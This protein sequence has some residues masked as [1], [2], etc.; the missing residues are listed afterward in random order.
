MIQIFFLGTGAGSPSKKRKLPAF[1]VRREGLN[2]LLDCGEGTQYT[3]MNNKLGINSIKIIGITHMHGDHVFGLLGVI[4]SM[5]L[6][7]RK[8]TLYILGPRDL[9]DFLYTS[10]EYSKF[11]P[12]F[13]IEF[14]DNYNDQNITISTFKTCHTVESQGYLISERDRVKIDEEKL[15]KEKIKDWR[16]M[17]KLKE[18]K[19]V[20]YNGKLLKP[21]DYLVIK[22]GLKVAYTGDTMPC[23][24]VIESVKGVDLLI[25]D[26][27][28][29]NE[30]SAYTYGHSNIADAA[31]VALEASVKLLALTHISPRYEDVTEHLK[32][33]RR[34][35]PKSILPDDL[36]YITLK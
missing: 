32:V 3:L 30:P 16:V 6:L 10:F 23:Q 22:R 9:K 36:S 4:A 34:I 28:F 2:I 15:E 11:N 8:E 17:R 1:L 12:S 31:K 24:S 14:I 33:A 7:D 25:H 26:S 20:E 13:K 35:F 5:G 29:L 18:G 27:T 21:E 19:T